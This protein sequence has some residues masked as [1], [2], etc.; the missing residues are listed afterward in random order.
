MQDSYLSE[1]F[2]L[3]KSYPNAVDLWC[4]NLYRGS[5]FGP[6]FDSYPQL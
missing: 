3:E 2:A 1:Y 4:L 6:L 5:T